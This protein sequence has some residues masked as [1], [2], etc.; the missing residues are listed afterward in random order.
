MSVVASRRLASSPE[1]REIIV[2][3]YAPEVHGTCEVRCR[4]RITGLEHDTPEEFEA[5]GVDSVQ[6]LVIALTRIGDYLKH[7]DTPLT[8]LD[9]E[10]LG[11]PITSLPAGEGVVNATV[12]QQCV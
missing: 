6:A 5:F 11:F 3:I 8:F 2:E 4:Y 12:S 9:S 10:F 1:G 7:S